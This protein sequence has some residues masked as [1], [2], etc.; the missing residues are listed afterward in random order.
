[1]AILN[2]TKND[3]ENTISSGTTLVDF[4]AGW[5]M[6]CRMLAPVIGEIA[7]EFAERVKTAKVNVDAEGELAMKYGV[8]S[9]PTVILF[10]NGREEKRFIGVQPKE[11]YLQAL[12]PERAGVYEAAL[13]D[14]NPG[15]GG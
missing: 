7:E 3:F 15:A 2:L 13:Q 4:W 12:K 6:P 14:V 10:R 5:C 1:M 8:M 11:V 9:I